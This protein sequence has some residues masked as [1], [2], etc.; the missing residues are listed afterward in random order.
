[1]ALPFRSCGC[2]GCRELLAEGSAVVGAA[3]PA[4]G[5]SAGL[6]LSRAWR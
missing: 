1:M 2:H 3:D 5:P 6:D 4:W